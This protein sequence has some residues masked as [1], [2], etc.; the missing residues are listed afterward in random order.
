MHARQDTDA[1]KLLAMLSFSGEHLA[2]L[3]DDYLPHVVRFPTAN[4]APGIPGARF[5]N[6]AGGD[7]AIF[8]DYR[9]ILGAL[10]AFLAS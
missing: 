3:P 9:E 10:Q 7:L 2:E 6:V 5:L 4:I 8:E 1:G